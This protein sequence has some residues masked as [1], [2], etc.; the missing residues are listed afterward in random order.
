VYYY[1]TTVCEPM[2][3][4]LPMPLSFPRWSTTF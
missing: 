4:F 2:A 1:F 3:Q